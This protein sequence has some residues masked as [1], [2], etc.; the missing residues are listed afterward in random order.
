[1]ALTVLDEYLHGPWKTGG[2]MSTPGKRTYR[3]RKGLPTWRLVCY[4]D[5]FVVLV[6][7]NRDD[8]HALHEQIAD[9]LA[10]L[11]LRFSPAKTRIVHMSEAFDFLGFASSGGASK[12]PAS[13]T[14]TPSS[15]TGRSGR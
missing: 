9:V 11:G 10:G 15:L 14:S 3:R 13:G 8:V 7:G 2:T 5:D 1:M 12:A 6:H 4:A